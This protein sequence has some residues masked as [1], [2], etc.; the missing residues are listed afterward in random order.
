MEV[1]VE[2]EEGLLSPPGPEAH[3]ICVPR[4][5]PSFRESQKVDNILRR[6]GGS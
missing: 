4:A 5:H 2:K 6:G 1:T 3:G